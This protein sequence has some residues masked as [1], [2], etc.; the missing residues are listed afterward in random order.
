MKAIY[1]LREIRFSG[2]ESDISVAVH[3]RF[4]TYLEGKTEKDY[5]GTFK[6][7]VA[8]NDKDGVRAIAIDVDDTLG[9]GMKIPVTAIDL[10]I[11]KTEVA[12]DG[13]FWWRPGIPVTSF[14]GTNL[15]VILSGGFR[16][17]E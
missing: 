1:K 17:G 3:K 8:S 13:S 4:M 12:E 7:I 6:A 15:G 5:E 9:Q 14:G 16:K 2:N 11:Y 10:V